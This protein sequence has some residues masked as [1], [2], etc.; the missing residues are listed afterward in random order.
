MILVDT[1]HYHRT[2][3]KPGGIGI[4]RDRNDV[5]LN[6]RCLSFVPRNDDQM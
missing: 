6:Y 3:A 2:T 1:I 4:G 5:P